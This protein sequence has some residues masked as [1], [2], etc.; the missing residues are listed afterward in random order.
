MFWK[1]ECLMHAFKSGRCFSF[2]WLLFKSS[3][4]YPAYVSRSSMCRTLWGIRRILRHGPWPQGSQVRDQLINAFSYLSKWVHGGWFG[5]VFPMMAGFPIGGNTCLQGA[6]FQM[7]LTSIH[8][9]MLSLLKTSRRINTPNRGDT[10]FPFLLCY[11]AV[12]VSL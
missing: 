12:S 9:F 10:A 7:T 8:S 1:L 6:A 3:D 2:C 11:W 4:L 5:M